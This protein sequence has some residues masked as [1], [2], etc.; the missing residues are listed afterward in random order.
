MKNA[1]DNVTNAAGLAAYLMHGYSSPAVSLPGCGIKTEPRAAEPVPV[2]VTEAPRRNSATG[3]GRRIPSRYMVQ[4]RGRW[5]R[6]YICQI[7]NAGSAYIGRSLRDGIRVDLDR[8]D[9]IPDGRYSLG[10]EY[11]GA[12]LQW[13]ARFLGDWVGSAP[14]QW[15]A[16]LLIRDHSA[17]RLGG[18]Q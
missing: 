11:T 10:L 5:R 2:R 9:A 12:G 17:A 13:V 15:R 8:F 6:V 14:E 4:W 18:A 1:N 16:A 7:S 3:Y